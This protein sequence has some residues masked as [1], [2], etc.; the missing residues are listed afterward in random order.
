MTVSST[1]RTADSVISAMIVRFRRAAILCR[2][3]IAGV[4]AVTYMQRDVKS[5][6]TMLRGRAA[7]GPEVSDGVE[8]Q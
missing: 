3:L 7:S 1:L 4:A 2:R 8:Q 6:A 5:K